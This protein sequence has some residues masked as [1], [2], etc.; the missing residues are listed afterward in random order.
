MRTRAYAAHGLLDS[1][2]IV[3]S[4]SRKAVRDRATMQVAIVPAF[5]SRTQKRARLK[6][7]ASVRCTQPR[8]SSCQ[9]KPSRRPHPGR[10]MAANPAG[11]GPQTRVEGQSNRERDSP[12]TWGPDR[13]QP[14]HQHCQYPAQPQPVDSTKP[15]IL[16]RDPLPRRGGCAGWAER[17]GVRSHEFPNYELRKDSGRLRE[18]PTD[19]ARRASRVGG[20]TSGPFPACAL[21]SLPLRTRHLLF[22][23]FLNKRKRMATACVH[24]HDVRLGAAAV[25]VP[26]YT[27]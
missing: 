27:Y 5:A 18:T 24:L 1:V 23:P 10:T 4:H 21:S 7:P 25:R 15:R 16:P 3:C 26:S 20:Q 11:E 9:A 2:C 6:S 19:R 8:R 22:R 17:R 13:C 14:C 12:S